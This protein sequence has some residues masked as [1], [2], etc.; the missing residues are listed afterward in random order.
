MTT[1]ETPK[2]KPG[3]IVYRYDGRSGFVPRRVTQWHLHLEKDFPP[4][5]MYRLDEDGITLFPEFSL[6]SKGE[7]IKLGHKIIEM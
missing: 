7:L 4:V 2:Y 1:L 3:D 6:H 5:Y